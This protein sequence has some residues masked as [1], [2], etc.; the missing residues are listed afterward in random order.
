[1]SVFMVETS[2]L[3]SAASSVTS[4]AS[5]L[6]SVSDSVNGYDTANE[7][8]F[9]FDSAKS[10]IAGNIAACATK[11]GNAANILQTVS[12]SHTD[13][14]NGL[15]FGQGGTTNSA[16][17]SSAASSQ[18][19]QSANSN[20]GNYGGNSGSG[21]SSGGS[22]GYSGGSGGSSGGAVPKYRLPVELGG[23]AIPVA[24]TI[25][26]NN[27]KQEQQKQNKNR[28]GIVDVKLSS[29]GYA[30]IDKKLSDDSKKLFADEQFSY[31]NG[32]AKID[33]NYVVAC[34]SSIGEVGDVIKFKQNDGDV[35]SGVIGVSTHE[36]NNADKLYFIVDKNESSLKKSVVVD[37]LI[38]D[39]KTIENVGS[40]YDLKKE[41]ISKENSDS[42]GKNKEGVEV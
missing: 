30:V 6:Q 5:D 42:I 1:M 26:S 32:Y 10:V 2:D 4:L 8:G 11:M 40:I 27:D 41:S 37:N 23:Q 36:K 29:S 13:L 24:A 17:K 14:Q 15:K 38:K 18:N 12:T 3:D 39:N 34:D 35:V 9:D 19:S 31:D 28:L 21:R 33:D 25:G 16:G 7:D 22:G 20:S